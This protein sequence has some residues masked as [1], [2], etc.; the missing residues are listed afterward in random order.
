M[1]RVDAAAD[2]SRQVMELQ[3]KLDAQVALT[4]DLRQQ[5]AQSTAAAIVP[6]SHQPS[7][8]A[9]RA[10]IDNL[11]KEL[12]R[13]LARNREL[14]DRASA[15]SSSAAPADA[16]LVQQ[17]ADL[18]RQL[19]DERAR[20]RNAFNA[21]A[22]ASAMFLVS[23]SFDAGD[24][25]PG[26]EGSGMSEVNLWKFRYHHLQERIQAVE[27]ELHES[28]KRSAREISALRIKVHEQEMQLL[29]AGHQNDSSFS[30][31]DEK[32]NALPA[33][34]GRAGSLGRSA[35]SRPISGTGAAPLG[36]SRAPSFT[37]D[38]NRKAFF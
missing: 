25:P 33:G 8:D 26:G 5:L 20:S 14:E 4:N 6:T 12:S 19:E 22:S 11:R 7:S 2:R 24:D 35:V 21:N 1:T 37:S 38:A 27:N 16:H 29:A 23:P 28:A 9:D 30:G 15:A 32:T 34:F 3:S 17:V 36:V 10:A 31:S 13:Q 18:K